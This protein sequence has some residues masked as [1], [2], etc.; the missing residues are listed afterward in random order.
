MNKTT[1]D[2]PVCRKEVIIQGNT[3]HCASCGWS[4]TGQQLEKAIMQDDKE[5]FEIMLE[6]WQSD[7]EELSGEIKILEIYFDEDL[8]TWA[9]YAE[10]EEHR[11]ILA[12][13]HGTGDITINYAGSK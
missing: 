5:T 1:I 7:H 2:C 6:E 13:V 12:D 9:A 3:A 4:A 10:D 11:Y 8:E